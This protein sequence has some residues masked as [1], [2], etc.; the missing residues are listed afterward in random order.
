[1]TTLGKS[2]QRQSTQRQNGTKSN[3]LTIG[4]T[5][6]KDQM[7][8]W[9]VCGPSSRA[10][11]TWDNFSLM[12]CTIFFSAIVV[13][14][15]LI[16]MNIFPIV[17]SLGYKDQLKTSSELKQNYSFPDDQVT[18]K[19]RLRKE[20]TK[21]GYVCVEKKKVKIQGQT[22]QHAQLLGIERLIVGANK[23]DDPSIG[24]KTKEISFIPMS[25]IQKRKLD[26]SDVILMDD[27]EKTVS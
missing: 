7:I 4:P 11:V 18:A 25:G 9:Q 21:K 17:Q 24:Y 2:T 22:Q 10:Q 16:F 8:G 19:L 23:M 3:N 1:M 6:K 26:K 5:V 27:L 12:Y 13:K 14:E 20:A 15:Y